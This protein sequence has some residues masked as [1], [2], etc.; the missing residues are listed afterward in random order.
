M[1]HRPPQMKI[2]FHI[3]KLIANVQMK[4][5]RSNRKQ[6]PKKPPT[7]ALTTLNP[8]VWTHYL[9]RNACQ[10]SIVTLLFVN[11][12]SWINTPPI[13]CMLPFASN[14]ARSIHWQ[15]HITGRITGS[16]FTIL[17]GTFSTTFFA[18]GAGPQSLSRIPMML[19]YWQSF[20]PR[21]HQV[22]TG[23]QSSWS[24]LH[25]LDIDTGI[26]VC[27]TANHLHRMQCA[28]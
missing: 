7:Q 22:R 23:F 12:E 3:W 20:F 2:N 8:K 14:L 6:L 13:M 16:I 1:T 24:L 25:R 9:A 28:A 4:T 19:H 18:F 11:L 5:T 26:H 10:M 17:R 15:D 27:L 21:P